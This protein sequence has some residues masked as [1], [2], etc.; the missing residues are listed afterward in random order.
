MIAANTARNMVSG[1]HL[2]KHP[3]RRSLFTKI[4]SAPAVNN[5]SGRYSTRMF[6]TGADGRKL[7]A[8]R[9]DVARRAHAHDCPIRSQCASENGANGDRQIIPRRKRREVEHCFACN[10]AASEHSTHTMADADGSVSSSRRRQISQAR[11][12]RKAKNSGIRP[13]GTRVHSA[14]S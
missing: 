11:S 10:G 5:T 8:R 13:R 4:V 3:S 14:S 7:T 1:H 9:Y 12:G 6:E 2:Q